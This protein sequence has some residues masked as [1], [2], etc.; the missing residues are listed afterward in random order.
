MNPVE[1]AGSVRG[2]R[3]KTPDQLAQHDLSLMF[4]KSG[5][6][7]RFRPTHSVHGRQPQPGVLHE[8]A[9][10]EDAAR[11]AVPVA[12]RI[13][14]FSLTMV[15]ICPPP[16]KRVCARVPCLRSQWGYSTTA[17]IER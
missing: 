9:H 3:M 7:W 1:A 8:L 16:H 12:H 10:R 13:L 11:D 17:G 4:D 5:R 6:L 14:R 15:C 2:D